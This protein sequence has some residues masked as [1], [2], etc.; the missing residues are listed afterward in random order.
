LNQQARDLYRDE[1]LFSDA[2]LQMAGYAAALRVLTKYT[3]IDGKDMPEEA[4]RPRVRGQKTV[5]DELIEFAVATANQALVPSG[6]ARNHWDRLKPAERFYLKMLELEAHGAKTL[7]N[8]QNF[9]KAF[10]VQD[11]R[12][13]MASDRANATRFKSAVEFGRAEMNQTSELYNT[14]L[15]GLLYAFMELQQEKDG[16][17]VLAHLQYNVPEYFSVRDRLADLSDYLAKTLRDLRPDEAS[18]ARVMT[19]LIRNER[20]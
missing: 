11:F 18:A 2:D 6:I 16:S 4:Q 12:P 20:L 13:F 5:V 7:D 15:R 8:Y 19:S 14:P 9:A 17:E 3:V 10:K 1:N